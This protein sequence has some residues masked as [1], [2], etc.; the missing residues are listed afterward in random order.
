[1]KSFS[2]RRAGLLA[3][4][5]YLVAAGCGNLPSVPTIDEIRNVPDSS[6]STSS[7]KRSTNRGQSF[8][9]IGRRHDLGQ[10]REMS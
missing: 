3:L 4:T 10:N 5:V 8:S 9:P 7:R 1:M 2:L 6:Q